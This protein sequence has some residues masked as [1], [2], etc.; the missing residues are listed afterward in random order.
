M[1]C[2]FSDI[3]QIFFPKTCVI[4]ENTLAY[5]EE[6]VCV[7][8][9]AG[10]SV[11]NFTQETENQLEKNFYGRVLLEEGTALLY[12]NV[13]NPTQK[14]LHQLKYKGREDVGVFLGNWLGEEISCSER[15]KGIEV[16]MPVPLHPKKER[17]RGY[18]QVTEFG[19]CISGFLQVPFVE[20][21][22]IRKVYKESQTKKD[23][24][25]RMLSE[26]ILRLM[27]LL[28]SGNKHVLLLDD[29]VTTGSYFRGLLPGFVSNTRDKNKCCSHGL[30]QLVRFRLYNFCFFTATRLII[31][32]KL[33][34]NL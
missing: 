6:T 14:L 24:I 22:L 21:V 12:Y 23:R 11:T 4:C 31:L 20:N 18:N 29:V 13:G 19:K 33:Y 34:V 15:F 1:R 2:K 17:L 26:T 28:L 32:A 7:S 10:L 8:C 27:T 3:I 30:Y 5:R 9:R 16:V 25:H